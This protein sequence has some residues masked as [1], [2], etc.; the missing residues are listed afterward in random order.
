MDV[1]A[2]PRW[3]ERVRRAVGPRRGHVPARP[4]GHDGPRRAPLRPRHDDPRDIVGHQPRLADRPRRAARRPVARH[5]RALDDAPPRTHRL[6]R[7]PRAAADHPLRQRVGR[8]PDGVRPDLRLRAQVRHLG[9]RGGGLQRGGGQRRRLGHQ[10]H[11]HDRP[12][13]RLR[14]L[15]RP[16][17]HDPARRRHRLRR[18][19][20]LRAR[21]PE[22]LRAG[23]RPPG[24]D[25]RLLASMARPWLLP[26]PSVAPVPATQRPDTQGTELQP[27][28]RDDRR[29]DHQPPGDARRRAQLGLPLQLG[30]R[31][32]VHALGPALARLRVGGQRLLLLHAGRRA[33]GRPAG[34]VRH[35]GRARAG[36]GDARPPLRLRRRPPRAHRQRR[37]QPAPAR[38]VGHDAGLDLPA[39]QVPR[40]PAR[41]ALAADRTARR[42]RDR[43]LGEAGQG[44]LGGPRRR[45]ALHV[46]EGHVLGRVRPRLTPRHACA[47][48][49]STLVAGAPRRTRSRKTSSP[50]AARTASS[51]STT[52]PTRWTPAPC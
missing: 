35:P 40:P 44:H 47:K 18:P 4:G 25:R 48:P 50:A 20:L 24:Q 14:G 31:Q 2:A 39:R 3:A 19:R 29:R 46:L 37:L 34:D 27:H 41:A 1:P 5:R 43:E 36:R 10:A 52:R 11:A 13:R 15:A 7:R 9:V 51:P 42:G 45:Q 30:P 23:L 32:H 16:R 26:G 38:R 12:A 6:R 8:G 21:R 33:G 28:R 17:G 49:T 22:D